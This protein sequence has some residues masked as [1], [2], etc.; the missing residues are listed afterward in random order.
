MNFL[1]HIFLSGKSEKV[2]IGNFIGD[3]VKGKD[4]KSYPT[5]IS[6]GILLHRHIDS[7]TDTHEMVR[8]SKVFFAADYHKYAG[9]VV[10]V[11]YDYFLSANWDRFSVVKID[12]F[13]ERVHQT[14]NSNFD[15]LPKPVQNFVPLFIRDNWLK[16]YATLEGIENVLYRMQ[17]RTSLPKATEFAM[18]VIAANYDR[19]QE[20]F[21]EFFPQIISYVEK[22]F[23]VI[24]DQP[25][26]E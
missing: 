25:Y 8:N 9:V 17:R 3:Y 2:L 16:T 24:I 12:P 20:N 10:D 7:F 11:L 14:L 21:L 13:I 5:E 22:K 18:Q 19:L 23:D 26:E 4:F 1:A 6:E 15:V